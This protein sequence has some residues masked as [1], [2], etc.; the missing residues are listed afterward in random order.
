MDAQRIHNPV[1]NRPAKR[2]FDIKEAAEYLGRTVG[3]LREMLYAGKMPFVR[4]G[5]RILIDIHDMDAWID[6]SKTQ[7]LS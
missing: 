2:L 1:R 5:R 6:R 3:A 4:D 7:R